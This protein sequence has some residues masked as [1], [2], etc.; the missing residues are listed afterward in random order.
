MCHVGITVP[1]CTILLVRHAHT[2]MAGRFCGEADPPLSGQGR[3]Q[4]TKLA[5]ALARYPLTH[6]FSSDLRRAQQ[7]AMSVAAG[8]GLAVE[9]LPALRE[10][11]FGEWEGLNWDQASARDAAYAERWM[12]EYPRLP[13]PGGEQFGDFRARVRRAL[14]E[15]AARTAG[16]CAAVVTHS[17][18]IRTFLLD[19]LDLP[20]S[21]L[22]GLACEYASCVELRLRAGRWCVVSQGRG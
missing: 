5:E 6:V 3:N 7:T 8:P 9:L 12:A 14:A 17:G 20:E 19:V 22:A 4:L 2:E 1:D 10:M 18:V 21:A 13:A 15:V 16:G 11:R